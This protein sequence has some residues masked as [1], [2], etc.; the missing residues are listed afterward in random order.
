MSEDVGVI[1][2]PCPEATFLGMRRWG[3]TREQYDVPA[4]RRHSQVAA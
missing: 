1:Q 2:L 4:F 3:M